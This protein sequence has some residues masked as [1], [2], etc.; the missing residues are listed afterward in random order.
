MI[1]KMDKYIAT[2][3]AVAH[4]SEST[5]VAIRDRYYSK[6]KALNRVE[7]IVKDFEIDYENILNGIN[8]IFPLVE[9]NENCPICGSSM[10]R[11]PLPKS[12]RYDDD[13]DLV[14]MNCSHEIY[15]EKASKKKTCTCKSCNELTKQKLNRIAIY[16]ECTEPYKWQDMS[17]LDKIYV[18]T[19]Y[20]ATVYKKAL[21]NNRVENRNG[22]F[23]LSQK[24]LIN[25]F[26]IMSGNLD[27]GVLMYLFKKKIIV[28]NDLNLLH[29]YTNG[30]MMEFKNIK[31]ILDLDFKINLDMTEDEFVESI[32]ELDFAS[33]EEFEMFER[34]L[35]NILISICVDF[36]Q[37]ILAFNG[38][39]V[40]RLELSGVRDTIRELLYICSIGQ[41]YSI[42]ASNVMWAK[43][44]DFISNSKTVE[45]SMNGINKNAINY[46]KYNCDKIK[47]FSGNNKMYKIS[48]LLN[49][50]SSLKGLKNP[51]EFKFDIQARNKMRD[52]FFNDMNLT[53]DGG[54]EHDLFIEEVLCTKRYISDAEANE[55]AF[56]FSVFK[57]NNIGDNCCN[58]IDFRSE[59]EYSKNEVSEE[60][61]FPNGFSF[62]EKNIK[63]EKQKTDENILKVINCY[64]KFVG[65]V[66]DRDLKLIK[67][68][69]EIC[70][71]YQINNAIKI[72]ANHP[73]LSCNFK[74]FEYIV[75]TIKN[76][77]FGFRKDYVG[78]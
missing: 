45:V 9:T 53:E 4:L 17:Y 26:N 10:L 39:R 14:C 11:L 73:K 71:P 27:E 46:A 75:P 30:T 59:G 29:K 19:F 23:I 64:T 5:I 22:L 34:S 50:L 74:S 72:T 21:E 42:I 48:M 78:R 60:N 15:R 52:S 65:D 63:S 62:P 49:S 61:L 8:Y 58:E 70:Y 55:L 2:R 25:T 6:D 18:F 12:R 41:I 1:N 76:G 7:T 36:F 28:P 47:I 13:T 77:A 57:G 38:I 68:M 40:S 31:D 33:K 66:D 37:E 67:D 16:N 3:Q 69:C 51:L 54:V 56:D 44:K 43:N 20:K 32:N 35:D 24:T